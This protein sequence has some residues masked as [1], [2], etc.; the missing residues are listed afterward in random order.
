MGAE[1]DTLSPLGNHISF[2]R[3]SESHATNS[4]I[5]EHLVVAIADMNKRVLNF[6]IR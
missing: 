1:R 2:C 4:R 6:E 5:E 3:L